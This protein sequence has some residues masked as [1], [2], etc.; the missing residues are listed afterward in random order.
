MMTTA[1]WLDGYHFAHRGL[2]DAAGGIIENTAAAAAAAIDADYGIEVDLRLS[3][4]GEAVVF[5]DAT[6]DRLTAG[7]GAVGEQTFAQLA[8]VQF[9][10]APEA[11][12]MT[13]SALLKL[14]AGQVPLLLEIKSGWRNIGPLE[15]RIAECLKDYSGAVAV[16][17]FDPRSIRWFRDHAPKVRRGLVACDF[18][19]AADWPGLSWLQRFRLRHLLSAYTVRPGFI[20]F[21]V[22]ALP[23]LATRIARLF[24]LPVLVWTVRSQDLRRRA[25]RYGDAIIFEQIRPGVVKDG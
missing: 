21:D 25:E 15:K 18:A 14:V 8:K 2:H 13:L 16:M 4:D 5:H 19:Q 11:R 24:G 12:I 3:G 10:D 9:K 22:A 20:A 6:L 17:S 7:A 1:Q 23:T